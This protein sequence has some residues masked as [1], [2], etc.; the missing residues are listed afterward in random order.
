VKTSACALVLI[1]SV[2]LFVTGSDAQGAV[3]L[4]S[5]LFGGI[6]NNP[7][8]TPTSAPTILG[9]GLL[10]N[11]LIDRLGGRSGTGNQTTPAPSTGEIVGVHL[12]DM[13]VSRGADG[14]S[15]STAASPAATS[16]KNF[17]STTAAAP[18]AASYAN[19]STTYTAAASPATSSS[20]TSS[21]VVVPSTKILVTKITQC[22]L[23]R[24]TKLNFTIIAQACRELGI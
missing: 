20:S 10:G 15:P 5:R 17:T 12:T 3:P 2:G 22:P 11:R 16:A 18:P 9:Q 7:T 19:N 21:T 14:S 8:T 23:P 6:M 13:L 1:I 24:T 4:G